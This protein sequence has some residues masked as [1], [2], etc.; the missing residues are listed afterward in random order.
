M[1]QQQL[2]QQT[3]AQNGVALQHVAAQA[4]AAAAQQR[5]AAAGKRPAEPG[6]TDPAAKRVKKEDDL[7]NDVLAVRVPFQGIFLV[8]TWV[9]G[10]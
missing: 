4:A 1:L 5:A 6:A 2:Q 10:S 7:G 9:E 3:P 8:V